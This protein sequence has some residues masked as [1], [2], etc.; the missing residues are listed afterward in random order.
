MDACCMINLT[1]ANISDSAGIQM[2]L[3]AIRKCWPWVKH[4]FANGAYDRLKFMDK[5]AYLDFILEVIRRREGTR[6]FEV[7]PRRWVVEQTFG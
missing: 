7:L 6:G 2:I 3:S 4:L 5:A 1:F